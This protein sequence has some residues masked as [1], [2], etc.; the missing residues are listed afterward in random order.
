MGHFS[1]ECP[2]GPYYKRNFEI[3][4]ESVQSLKDFDNLF[5]RKW[6]STI[7]AIQSLERKEKLLFIRLYHRKPQWFRL[8]KLHYEEIGASLLPLLESLVEKKLMMSDRSLS[9]LQETLVILSHSELSALV[10]QFHLQGRGARSKAEVMALFEEMETSQRTLFSTTSFGQQVITKAKQTFGRCFKLCDDIRFLL[11]NVE[12]IFFMKQSIAPNFLSGSASTST[13]LA[14]VVLA[15]KGVIR[16]PSYK[17]NVTYTLF[18][19]HSQLTEYTSSLQQEAALENE[20]LNAHNEDNLIA[21]EE[22]Y[23][24]VYK[25]WKETI[26]LRQHE[27]LKCED[28]THSSSQFDTFVTFT[29]TLVLTRIVSSFV[30]ILDRLHKYTESER[31]HRELLGQTTCLKSY[32]GRWYDRLA[33]I[34]SQHLQQ[35]HESLLVCERGI[36]D[37]NVRTGHKLALERRAH[38]LCQRHKCLQQYAHTHPQPFIHLG[39]KILLHGRAMPDRETGKKMTFMYNT[40]TLCSVEEF[41]IAKFVERG[42][43]GA[44]CEGTV[45]RTL[46]GLLFWNIIYADVPNVFFTK[47]QIAPADM[48]TD[49][50]YLRRKDVIKRRLREL[51]SCDL[52]KEVLQC[53]D[54]HFPLNGVGISW[55][56]LSREDL[57]EAAL[58]LGND[59]VVGVCDIFCQDYHHRA[60]GVPDLLLWKLSTPT[61]GGNGSE[62]QQTSPPHGIATLLEVKS[63]N[64]TLADKQ[65]IWI[66]VLTLLGAHVALCE[67]QDFGGRKECVEG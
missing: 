43:K 35:P 30:S 59:V 65:K 25:D 4:L 48:F 8:D 46:F 37:P 19:T 66:H 47:Y 32:R 55:T 51:S 20:L 60:G 17:V 42:W 67:V 11:A 41:V 50:F 5:P 26:A 12:T 23:R 64:D 36:A 13:G 63:P 53:W 57:A 3:M 39:K 21:V 16:Y 49:N 24:C 44:H 7:A 56:L 62:A 28:E 27:L 18:K 6:R 9:S 10:R 58:C 38:R 52:Q 14:T 29:P 33:L 61:L 54:E 45:F 31:L 40:N 22:K 1:K 15:N 2:E 34:L